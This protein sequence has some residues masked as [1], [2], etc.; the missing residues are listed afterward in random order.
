MS[1]KK[2]DLD[3]NHMYDVNAKATLKKIV[4]FIKA[5]LNICLNCGVNISTAVLLSAYTEFFGQCL[6]GNKNM[7]LKKRYNQ[8]LRRMGKP[9]SDIL[10]NGIDL[11]SRIRCGLIH[12][13][14]IKDGARI[15]TE[16]G[17]P[18]IEIINNVIC[19][20]NRQYYEDFITTVDKYVNDI[21]TD[22]ELQNN[23][24]EFRKG[25]PPVR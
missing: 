11:Y 15:F 10:D 3:N 21:Q 4:E 8:W 7:Y 13:F 18:G 1:Q 17:P 2:G 14:T 22:H 20:N 23:Y 16:T 19:F 9:Y 6:T 24:L 5:D 25:K 12:E